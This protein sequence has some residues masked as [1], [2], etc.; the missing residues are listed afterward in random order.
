MPAAS[1]RSVADSAIA[2]LP[3]PGDS[4]TI[5][6]ADGAGSGTREVMLDAISIY[7]LVKGGKRWE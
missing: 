6:V 3:N 5:G 1:I 2:E 4:V 7:M